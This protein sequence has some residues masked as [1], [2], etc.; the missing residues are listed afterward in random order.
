MV[1]LT[2]SQP[3][4]QSDRH[5]TADKP[6][7]RR[8]SSTQHTP[9]PVSEVTPL[10]PISITDRAVEVE[11]AGSATPIAIQP[12]EGDQPEVRKL[13]KYAS[14]GTLPRAAATV[15]APLRTGRSLTTRGAFSPGFYLIAGHLDNLSRDQLSRIS[16]EDELESGGTLTRS[17][18]ASED[19][20]QSTPGEQSDAEDGPGDMSSAM[21]RRETV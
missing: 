11:V 5:K 10:L 8:S 21:Q 20:A 4:Q 3:R 17:Q 9:R 7:S 14:I 12:I 2:R 16:S 19:S 1:V 13:R 6:R 18:S 15:V